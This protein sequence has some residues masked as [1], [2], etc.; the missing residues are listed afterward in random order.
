M[1]EKPT[2]PSSLVDLLFSNKQNTLKKNKEATILV[3]TLIE[4]FLEGIFLLLLSPVHLRFT[5][6]AILPIL[7]TFCN[8][9]QF[10]KDM[11]DRSINETFS[12]GSTAVSTSHLQKV[13]PQLL[14]EYS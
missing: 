1:E 7:F 3:K 12:Q 13:I 9:F 11:V 5:I 6:I 4:M 2:V 14:L 8:T 10:F